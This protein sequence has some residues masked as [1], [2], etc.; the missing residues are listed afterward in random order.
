MRAWG[1]DVKKLV[2]IDP[3]ASREDLELT[4][5]RRR[6]GPAGSTAKSERSSSGAALGRRGAHLDTLKDSTADA[7]GR[8]NLSHGGPGM[9][10]S[11]RS[12]STVG[13]RAGQQ[14]RGLRCASRLPRHRDEESSRGR[15][16]KF[17][18]ALRATAPLSPHA[19]AGGGAIVNVPRQRSSAGT[20]GDRLR[21]G[22]GA[23]STHKSLAQEFGPR[24]GPAH[25]VSPGPVSTDLWLATTRRRD[26]GEGE[27]CRRRRARE[28]RRGIGGFDTG[29]FKTPEEVATL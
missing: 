8:S 10:I 27:R 13:S 9:L 24:G 19:R 7:A 20:P 25:C 1:I 2:V 22:Q 21:R 23:W 16:T 28:R 12:T 26:G 17:S 29:S 15:E 6:T 18:A 14:R 11:A 5:G 4:K 3:G